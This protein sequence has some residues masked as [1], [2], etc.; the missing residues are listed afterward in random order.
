[1]EKQTDAGSGGGKGNGRGEGEGEE[2]EK[3]ITERS[4]GVMMGKR[5]VYRYLQTM[6]TLGYVAQEG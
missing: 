6:K 3:G 4:Q 1:M 5:T 2:R